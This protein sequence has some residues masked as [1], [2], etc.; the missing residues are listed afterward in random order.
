MKF[1]RKKEVWV[2]SGP[3][4][5]FL[6]LLLGLSVFTFF[7]RLYPFLAR[8]RP[9]PHPELV[10][11]EGWL[12]DATLEKILPKLEPDQRIVTSGG[13]ILYGQK[14]LHYENYA[15]IT[16]ARLIQM[17]ISPERIITAPA[18][19]TDRDRTFVSAKAVRQK[20]E[21][22]GLFGKS[23]ELYSVGA[24]S[25]RSYLLFRRVFGEGYPL[26]VIAIAPP[27]YHLDHW[28]HYSQGVRHVV[29]EFIAWI[30]AKFFMICSKM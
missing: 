25:R 14:I 9:L 5:I 17:G 11:I 27:Q 18:S 2:L 4:L 8:S 24:H 3:S 28:Y 13:P 7:F 1:F 12:P 29:G 10:L 19:E 15:E 20:L 26:G 6:L 22:L 16:A 30:Y 21:E 23:V